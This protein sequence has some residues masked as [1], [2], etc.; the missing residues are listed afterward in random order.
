[1]S[2]VTHFFGDKQ[3]I[4]PDFLVEISDQYGRLDLC[5][6]PVPLVF[7]QRHYGEAA[8][9]DERGVLEQ[10]LSF[11]CGEGLRGFEALADFDLDDGDLGVGGVDALDCAGADGGAL[12][13][14]VVEDPFRS[15][16]H[17]AQVLDCGGIGDAVPDG[18]LVAEEVIEGI[19]IGLS[20]EEEESG[21][22]AIVLGEPEGLTELQIYRICVVFKNFFLFAA[23]YRITDLQILRGTPPKK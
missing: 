5:H 14:G 7:G 21:H 9:E 19:H 8:Y 11:D 16:F 23:A 1:M 13:A 6:K 17:L 20:L 10:R 18:F 3:K 2:L 4:Q 15:G 12:V 22:G